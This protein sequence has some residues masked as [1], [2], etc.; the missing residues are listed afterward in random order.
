MLPLWGFSIFSIIIYTIQY[1]IG[2]SNVKELLWITLRGSIR[3]TCVIPALWFLSCLFCMDIIFK[4]IKQLEYKWMIFG[5][6]VILFII[7]EKLIVPRPI[8]EPHWLYNLDSAFYYM[9]Y[10]ATGYIAYP[11]LIKLFELNTKGKKLF[12]SFSGVA[13]F[14]YSLY[15]FW[16]KDILMMV[17][18]IPEIAIFSS[19][20]KA[21]ILIYLNLV[22]AKLI[23]NIYLL[24]EI[25]K[26]TLFL[27]G[28]EF[29]VKTLALVF[30]ELIGLKI[31]LQSPL[32]M[33]IYTFILLWIAVK[34]IIPMEKKII[35]LTMESLSIQ[36]NNMIV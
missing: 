25:G 19:F 10:Y 9:I 31:N 21:I 24:N 34:K 20:L 23:E 28:N 6:S 30:C 36:D 2:T 4:L 11:Y 14:V 13:C 27:C 12:F 15:L 29:V 26:E 3:N 17:D 22:V 8:V 18:T 35:S 33:Y 16:G 32:H 7:A 1:N 5:A